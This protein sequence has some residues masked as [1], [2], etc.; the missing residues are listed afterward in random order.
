MMEKNGKL[1]RL[2]REIRSCKKCPLWKTRKNTVPGE[3]PANAE[4]MCLGM[5][6][7]VE[8]DK[9]G[10]P[11]IGRAGKFLDELF[12][13]A[14]I[15]REKV[16][17]TSSLKCLPQPPPN[18]KPK[19]EEIEAC[20]PY[21]KKQIEIINPKKIILLGEIAFSVF[22][23]KKKLKNFRGKLIKKDD[24]EFFIT[25][26]PAAGIRFQRIKKILEEDFEKLP[27]IK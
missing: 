17:I 3:G 8:E 18:R 15:K 19:K 11:F 23:P 2:H 1:E 14:K 13:I 7:G 12:K 10:K 9:I 26:H 27:K 22:F 20:L 25:Y 24:K 16:F 4:I 5:A 6:P 21:L